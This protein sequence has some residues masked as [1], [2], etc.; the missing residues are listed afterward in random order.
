MGKWKAG[1]SLPSRR[2]IA[3][4]LSSDVLLSNVNSQAELPSL[5]LRH[6]RYLSE[7]AKYALQPKAVLKP[8]ES[9]IKEQLGKGF[10]L[11]QSL[12]PADIITGD[13][14]LRSKASY[15]ASNHLTVRPKLPPANFSSPPGEPLE[16]SS[17]SSITVKVANSPQRRLL[18]P[19]KKTLIL[20]DLENDVGIRHTLTYPLETKK[21][22]QSPNNYTQAKRTVAVKQHPELF[23]GSLPYLLGGVLIE[24]K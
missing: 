6:S 1:N 10:S 13:R 16:Q 3:H 4:Q 12:F 14:D 19:L 20:P 9:G 11:F 23:T 24:S 22:L 7:T 18:K 8:R 2:L 5:Q 17:P 21:H 15:R